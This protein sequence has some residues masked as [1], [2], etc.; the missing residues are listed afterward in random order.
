MI[1]NEIIA[2]LTE[3]NIEH[4]PKALKADLEALLEVPGPRPV[5]NDVLCEQKGCPDAEE[6]EDGHCSICGH[7]IGEYREELLNA[8]A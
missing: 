2:A 1:K 4:D 5:S 7:P 6:T 8:A 3:A